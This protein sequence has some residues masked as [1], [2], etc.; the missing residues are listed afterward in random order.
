ML[1]KGGFPLQILSFIINKNIGPNF[2]AFCTR[3]GLNLC[4]TLSYIMQTSPIFYDW[5]KNQ[6]LASL[7]NI[8]P[9]SLKYLKEAEI[10]VSLYFSSKVSSL[11]LSHS[12]NKFSNLPLSRSSLV[13]SSS[14]CI[15]LRRSVYAT[16][17]MY[18]VPCKALVC[19]LTKGLLAFQGT[20]ALKTE[21]RGS[22][23]D[24]RIN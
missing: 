6:S 24:H 19:P 7:K 21:H 2:P 13:Y 18:Y 23:C 12:S 16:V 17:L 8:E 22:H 10:I 1:W 14:K 15:L 20:D 3:I 5:K 11:P 9:F 4:Y